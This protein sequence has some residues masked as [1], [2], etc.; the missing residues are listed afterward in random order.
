MKLTLL[1]LFFVA[2]H[3]FAQTSRRDPYQIKLNDL[4]THQIDVRVLNHG[5][6][7]SE[8]WL[9]DQVR[10]MRVLYTQCG[11]N[12][13]VNVVTWLNLPS[14]QVQ[15]E[16]YGF[17]DR[18]LVM[19]NEVTAFFK[20]FAR[21]RIEG[22]FDLHLVDYLNHGVRQSSSTRNQQVTSGTA[23]NPIL[24]DWIIFGPDVQYAANSLFLA[25]ET[26]K[27][28]ERESF[29]R[30]N[31]LIG[32]PRSLSLLAHE[33]GHLVMEGQDARDGHYRDH[34]CMESADY[35]EAGNLMSGGGNDDQ[36]WRDPQSQRIKAYDLLPLVQV[37]QCQ[38]LLEHPYL[39]RL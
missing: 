6:R 13:K 20:S 38:K 39:I 36:V 23:F 34:W 25:V 4:Y 19:K 17:E 12:L 26:V 18:G 5:L 28:K 37:S 3:V 16:I 14:T 11:I 7:E 24:F 33:L 31:N 32:S 10:A 30:I 8:S 21:D 35:C 22:S 2:S 1:C 15:D 29:I 27:L 9:N